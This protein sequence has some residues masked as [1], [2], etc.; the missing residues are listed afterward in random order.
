LHT[1]KFSGVNRDRTRQRLN[2]HGH[3]FDDNEEQPEVAGHP[4]R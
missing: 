2:A 4:A 3:G 1:A